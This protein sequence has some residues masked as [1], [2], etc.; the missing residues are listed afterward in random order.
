MRKLTRIVTC[1][2]VVAFLGLGN[3]S[4]VY[5]QDQTVSQETLNQLEAKISTALSDINQNQ[6]TIAVLEQEIDGI[7][8]E[9]ARLQEDIQ[10]QKAIVEERKA[11][12]RNRL[13]S[14]QVTNYTKTSLLQLLEAESISDFMNRFWVVQQLFESENSHVNKAVSEIDKLEEMEKILAANQVALVT[15]KASV[16]ERQNLMSSGIADLQ[17]TLA[18]NRMAFDQLQARQKE[19]AEKQV[20]AAVQV[21]Q[22]SSVA[23]SQTDSSSTGSQVVA[24]EPATSSSSQKES[25]QVSSKP[26]DSSTSSNSSSTSSG[27]ASSQESSQ[28]K[29]P[30]ESADSSQ[31]MSGVK[32]LTVTATAYSYNEANLGFYTAMGIDLRVNP[33]VVA[34]DPS[35]IPLGSIVEVPGYGVAIAGDTGGAIKGNKIDLHYE[36]LTTAHNYGRQTI[37]IKVHP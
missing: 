15:K 18:D 4:S 16:D 19:E 20:A 9:Q 32:T 37:T 10:K 8:K 1:T 24:A 35:V 13:V 26:V 21:S 5:A 2:A 36:N 29:P 33:M 30:T 23:S 17:A 7:N 34:V 12:M 27:Q 28:L 14:I 3:V 25:S 6:L 31:E 11:I 22:A